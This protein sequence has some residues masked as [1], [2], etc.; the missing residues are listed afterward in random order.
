[1]ILALT[2]TL[3]AAAHA[4][5]ITFPDGSTMDGTVKEVNANCFDFVVNGT[6]IQF[7]REEVAQIEKN[8]KLPPPGKVAMIPAVEK[9]EREMNTETGLTADQ[10]ERAIVII[11]ELVRAHDADEH[12]RLEHELKALNKEANLVPFLKK[13]YDDLPVSPK[14]ERL[15]GLLVI[16]PKASLPLLKQGLEMPFAPMRLLCIENYAWIQESEKKFTRDAVECFA[17]GA[18]DICPE[19][20]IAS[21][22]ALAK[23]GD[24]AVTPALIKA[25]ETNEQRVNHV[26]ELALTALWGVQFPGP[27][28]VPVGF[29]QDHWKTHGAGVKDPID[30]ALLKPFVKRDRPTIVA[31]H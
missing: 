9:W 21:I 20:Q 29:W 1:M 16:E 18:V 11:G 4:D 27:P 13:N 26:T 2:V 28:Q 17:R 8:D 24:K 5:T 19:V 23:T 12:K 31:H 15:A 7:Q 6:A 3:A 30:A 25:L 14:M 22:Y 10:R